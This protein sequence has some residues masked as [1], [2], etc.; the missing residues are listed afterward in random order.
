VIAGVAAFLAYL[1]TIVP[2]QGMAWRFAFPV[3]P[4][5]LLAAC[6]AL[7]P[8]WPSRAGSRAAWVLP[9]M[10]LLI[11]WPARGAGGALRIAEEKTQHDRVV[12]GRA[13]AGL[14]GTMLTSEAGALPYYSGWRAVDLL[15]LTSER[16]AHEGLRP[17]LLEEL[18]P[19]LVVTRYDRVKGLRMRKA[20][21]P[22]LN[23]FLAGRGYVAIAAVAKNEDERHVYFARSG[24]PLY[25]EVA[26]R[27]RGLAGVDHVPLGSVP[28]DPRIALYGDAA[29]PVTP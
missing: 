10:A 23:D 11:W 5:L 19:D 2:I 8:V 26:S 1:A 25:A 20:A 14:D 27:L 3:L 18:R 24:S 4:A 29:A 9:L 7:S 21:A 17:A 13:L 15:G 28:I 12:A 6:V 16:I 22:V